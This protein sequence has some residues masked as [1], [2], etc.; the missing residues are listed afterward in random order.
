MQADLQQS[1]PLQMLGIS[2]DDIRNLPPEEVAMKAMRRGAEI[3][4]TDKK[5]PVGSNPRLALFSNPERIWLRDHRS[6]IGTYR[7]DEEG[8]G[9]WQIYAEAR[10]RE[11]RAGF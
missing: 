5:V 4:S 6:E 9:G 7:G 10:G 11:S 8:K 1:V 3:A 2:R